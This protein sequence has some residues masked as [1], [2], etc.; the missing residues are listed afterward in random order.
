MGIKTENKKIHF[1]HKICNWKFHFFSFRIEEKVYFVRNRHLK[2]KKIKE[3]QNKTAITLNWQFFF[4]FFFFFF[5]PTHTPTRQHAN[6]PTRQH[7][8]TPTR[9]HANTPTR[10]HANTPTRQH[11]NTPT[12][13]HTHT[14]THPPNALKQKK[15]KKG[16]CWGLPRKNALKQN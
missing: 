6:T 5:D 11:A 9:Q 16:F 10:Q 1:S 8:N 3:N 15:M 7:A 2:T 13:P 12:H 4:F 14:P